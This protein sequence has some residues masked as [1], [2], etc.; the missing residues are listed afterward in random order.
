MNAKGRVFQT[1]IMCFWTQ[2]SWA[3]S[4]HRPCSSRCWPLWWSIQRTRQR[5]GFS[6]ITW[7]KPR[8]SFPKSSL[9]CEFWNQFALKNYSKNFVILQQFPEL[10][11]HT[12]L[13]AKITNVLSLCHDQVILNAVQ[14][15]IQNMITLEDGSQQQPHYLQSMGFGGLWRF[16]GPFTKVRKI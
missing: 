4:R 13:D 5:C 9:S 2:K 16:A 15:I 8:S 3:M 11:S 1:R 14:N 7:R 12:L 10:F 6:M